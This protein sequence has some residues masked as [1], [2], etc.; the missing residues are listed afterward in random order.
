VA[1][2]AGLGLALIS[3][4]VEPAR[5]IAAP[6]AEPSPGE[7][8]LGGTAFPSLT[9]RA[10]TFT[11]IDVTAGRRLWQKQTPMP[12]VGGALATAGRLVFY[13]EGTPSGGAFVALDAATGAELF[14]FPTTGGVNAAPM[15]FVAQGKQL[16]TVAAGGNLLLLSRRD[17]LLITFELP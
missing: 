5:F 13:G 14:R 8:S 16:V 11:A 17:N 6:A 10:G 15:T 3:G 12:L 1:F 2:H 7:L 9:G 4:I